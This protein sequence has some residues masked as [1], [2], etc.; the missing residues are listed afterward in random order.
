MLIEH[1]LPPPDWLC[2]LMDYRPDPSSDRRLNVTRNAGRVLIDAKLA[3]AVALDARSLREA[4]A[5]L[6]RDVREAAES[7][8]NPRKTASSTSPRRIRG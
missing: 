3:D 5:T 4:T 2:E 7:A 8:G 6:Y 1:P